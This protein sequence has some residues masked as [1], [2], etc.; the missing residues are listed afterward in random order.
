MTK[1]RIKIKL[2]LITTRTEAEAVMNDLAIAANNRRKLAARMDAERLAIENKYAGTIAEC[3]A[4][5]KEKGDTLR[6][7]AEANPVEFGK[8]KS[9]EFLAGTL[10]FRTGTPKLALLNRSWTWEK[11]LG[12]LRNNPMY[13]KFVRTKPEVD[14]ERIISEAGTGCF[15]PGYCGMKVVQDESFYVEPNLTEEEQ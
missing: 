8:K 9:I 13:Q 6:A 14:K 3:D 1:E 5:V 11:V 10:G 4:F 7:W 15:D 12:V 2:P